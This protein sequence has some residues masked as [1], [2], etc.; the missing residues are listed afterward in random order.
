MTI[1]SA[2][3]LPGTNK[4]LGDRYLLLENL[5][6]GSHGW[7]WRAQRLSDDKIIAVKIRFSFH[8][9]LWFSPFSHKIP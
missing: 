6:D 2:H 8:S 9:L 4:K 5:G 1:N 3:F 7:V